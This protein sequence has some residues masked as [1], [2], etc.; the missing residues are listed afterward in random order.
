MRDIVATIQPEQ[1]RIVRARL[2]RLAVHPGRT[3]HRQDRGR[4]APGRLPAV[5]LPRP[6]RPLGRAGGR[7]ERQLLV[8][9]RRR[10]AG[11]GRDRRHPGHRASLVSR[12]H[13][14]GD[15]RP[16]PGAGGVDQGRRP[17]GRGAAPRGVGPRR[18]HRA[19]R[20][21]CRGGRTS[22][23]SAATSPT[24]S[25]TSCAAAGCATRPDGR[26]CRSGWPT[27]CCCGWRR[28][29]TP[30]TTGCRTRSPAAAR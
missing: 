11:A 19:R 5:R 20:W 22:G 21:W 13:R 12:R 10:A 15:P 6:A 8:L 23:G 26:C 27:R 16:G 2:T 25:S 29:A 28:P 24:R 1:D 18:P 14:G 17:D 30:P 9:H 7:A 4:A 3:R